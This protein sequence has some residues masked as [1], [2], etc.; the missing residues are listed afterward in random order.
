MLLPRT[1]K[2]KENLAKFQGKYP[3]SIQIMKKEDKK[4]KEC[5]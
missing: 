2:Y 1:D 4:D 3:G 5:E